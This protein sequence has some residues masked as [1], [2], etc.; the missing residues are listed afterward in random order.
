MHGLPLKEESR[1]SFQSQPFIFFEPRGAYLSKA[2]DYSLAN[3]PLFFPRTKEAPHLRS[4]SRFSHTGKTPALTSH[5]ST[6]RASITIKFNCLQGYDG[7]SDYVTPEFN[8]LAACR[9]IR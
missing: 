3:C 4:L 9:L 8:S 5:D 7:P 2:E 1:G 6:K